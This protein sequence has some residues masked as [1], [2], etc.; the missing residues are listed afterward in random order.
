MENK[1]ISETLSLIEEKF[2]SALERHS[3]KLPADAKD[4]IYDDRADLSV[5]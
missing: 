5:S 1:D 2:K 4:G 3:G